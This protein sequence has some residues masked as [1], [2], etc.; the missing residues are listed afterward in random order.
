MT[1]CDW[2][3]EGGS[4]GQPGRSHE[5]AR[6]PLFLSEGSDGHG[7]MGLIALPHRDRD[8]EREDILQ[9]LIHFYPFGTHNSFISGIWTSCAYPHPKPTAGKDERFAFGLGVFKVL[10]HQRKAA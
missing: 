4:V 9:C 1:H 7:F 10:S 6:R 2:R 8:R 5:E 3:L